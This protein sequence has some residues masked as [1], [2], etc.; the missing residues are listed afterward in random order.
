MP[1]KSSMTKESPISLLSKSFKSWGGNTQMAYLW[2][3]CIEWRNS[4]KQLKKNNSHRPPVSSCTYKENNVGRWNNYKKSLYHIHTIQFRQ[5][6]LQTMPHA[7]KYFRCQ[8]VRSANNWTPLALF[9]LWWM[10]IFWFIMVKKA[11]TTKWW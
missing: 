7:K 11:R 2:S 6:T 8:I 3:F 5:K 1:N 4:Y 10:L 9:P